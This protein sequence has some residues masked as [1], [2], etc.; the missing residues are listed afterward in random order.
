MLHWRVFRNKARVSKE[1]LSVFRTHLCFLQDEGGGNDDTLCGMKG[2]VQTKSKWQHVRVL[3]SF[4]F[5]EISS[6][7]MMIAFKRLW[8]ICLVHAVLISRSKQGE[9]GESPGKL[10]EKCLFLILLSAAVTAPAH[11]T[12]CSLKWNATYGILWLTDEVFQK[13]RWSG[14]GLVWRR[15]SWLR[16]GSSCWVNPSQLIA[17]GL[18][19]W[20]CRRQ[21]QRQTFRVWKMFSARC[22]MMRIW[23]L[24]LLGGRTEGGSNGNKT[25]TKLSK[26]ATWSTLSPVAQCPVP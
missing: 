16:R 3:D 13:R 7:G 5:W 6:Q 11:K 1:W 23:H 10:L 20:V 22:S 21:P 4:I 25:V 9:T 24:G 15:H 8:R 26:A 12:C 18:G 2:K 14:E 17:K 19:L